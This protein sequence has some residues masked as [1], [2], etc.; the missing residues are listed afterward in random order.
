MRLVLNYNANVR[1]DDGSCIEVVEG[2]T[3]SDAFNYNSEANTDDGSCIEVVEGRLDATACNYNELANTDDASCY[4]NDL[5][6]VVIY[7]YLNSII[8]VMGYV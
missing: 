3:D 4:N 2:C 7:L 6:C 5:G 1:F 8:I